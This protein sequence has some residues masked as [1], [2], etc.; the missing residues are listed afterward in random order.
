MR[1]SIYVLSAFLVLGCGGNETSN[2]NASTSAGA[3]GVSSASTGSGAGGAGGQG[4]SGDGSTSGTGTGGGATTGGTGGGGQACAPDTTVSCYSGPA[5]T[6]DVGTCHGGTKTCAADGTSYGPCT[7]E[8]TPTIENCSTPEDENCLGNTPDCGAHLWSERFSS[9]G[10][11]PKLLATAVD[12]AGSVLLTGAYHGTIDFG[13]GPLTT[14]DSLAYLAK[15]DASGTVQ[16]AKGF[17]GTGVQS[18]QAVAVDGGGNVVIAGFFTETMQVGNDVL[19][20]A[21]FGDV[22]VAKLDGAGNAL[23]AKRYGDGSLQAAQ[24]AAVDAAGN[25]VIAGAYGGT[26]GFGNHVVSTNYQ[27]N[28]FVAKLDP[29]GNELWIRDCGPVYDGLQTMAIATDAMGDVLV[30]A[31]SDFSMNFGGGAVGAPQKSG[32][33]VAKLD[34]NGEQVWSKAY[35]SASYDTAGGIAASPSGDVLI[36]GFVNGPTMFGMSEVP[37]GVYVAKLAGNGDEVWSKSFG[38]AGAHG[39]AVDAA[40][41]IAVVGTLTGDADFGTGM[42]STAG[43]KDVFVAKLDPLGGPGWAKRFGDAADQS[44]ASLALDPAG[45]VVIAGKLAGSADFGGGALVSAGDY[46]IFLAKLAL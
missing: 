38:A 3:G 7:G 4:G 18:S 31:T 11:G 23:W 34:P 28:M 32:I 25:V 10:P 41:N 26:L 16:W 15:F 2:S 46:D 40:G 39:V 30:T 13:T 33:F 24:A 17:G 36:T 35:D 45:N 21:G 42:L 22:F 9:V 27:S 12:S 43:G 37:A 6:E 14:D 29:A 5:A 1:T 8:I 19:T 20:G 44:G